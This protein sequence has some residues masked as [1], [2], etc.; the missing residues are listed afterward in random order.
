MVYVNVD[1]DGPLAGGAGRHA[2]VAVVAVKSW[3]LRKPEILNCPAGKGQ[4]AAFEEL[5]FAGM[6]AEIDHAGIS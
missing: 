3:S 5:D 2:D 6:R 4:Q 1:D